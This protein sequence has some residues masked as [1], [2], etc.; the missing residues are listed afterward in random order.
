MYDSNT[1]Q[2]IE[3]KVQCPFCGSTQLYA[4]K[5][6]FK[7]GC[8]GLLLLS[9]VIVIAMFW[10]WP[11]LLLLILFG[12]IGGNKV[13]LSCMQCGRVSRPGRISAVLSLPKQSDVVTL[14]KQRDVMSF[15]GVGVVLF[16]VIW[17]LVCVLFKI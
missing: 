10:F 14:P 8:F 1:G 3:E 11:I 9:P 6:G 15:M 4:G 12:F 16:V 2:L 7:L 5:R 13:R 17:F